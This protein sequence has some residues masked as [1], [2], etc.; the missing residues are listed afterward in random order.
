MFRAL[1]L[2]TVQLFCARLHDGKRANSAELARFHHTVC[3]GFHWINQTSG[4][5]R[6]VLRRQ[7]ALVGAQA[8]KI[9]SR[10]EYLKKQQ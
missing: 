3:L 9:Q 1:Q 7:G 4:H 10:V 8:N 5:W 6:T 2:R